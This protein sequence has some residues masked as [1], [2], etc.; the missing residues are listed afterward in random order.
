MPVFQSKL[1]TS[2]DTYKDNR[3]EMLALVTK[4]RDLEKRAASVSSKELPRFE[5]RG[6]LLPRERLKRLLDPGA[7][8]IEIGSMSGYL[9]DIDDPDKTV[10]G[11][12]L[13]AGIG[14]ISGVRCMVVVND[15]AIGAGALI[16]AGGEKFIRCQ[17]L[18][19]ANK[20]PFVQLVESAGADMA[21]Y[22]IEG[23]VR[24]GNLF[25]NLAR[26]SA[27]GCP[28]VTVLHGVSTAG[29]AY[30]SGLSDYVVAVRGRGRAFLAGPP[31]LKAATGEIASDE[32]LGGAEMHA[33]SSGLVEYLAEDDADGI[34][35][36]REVVEHL[37]WNDHVLLPPRTKSTLEPKYDP[38][39]IAGLVPLDYR[40]PYDV[41]ELIARLVDGSYMLDFKPRYGVTTV[42]VHGE[43][44]GQTCAFIGNNGPIDNAGATKAAQ[45]IQL[46][47]QSNTPI[48]YLQNTT[49]FMVGKEHESGGMIKH[50]SKMI[51][52]VTNS[53]VPQVTLMVGASFGAGNF[54][55][56]GVGFDPDL[57]FSWPNSQVGLMGAEQAAMTMRI[58]AERSA[59]R[60]G[61]AVNDGD[62]KALE[63]G[64][65][66]HFDYQSNPFYYA[67]QNLCDGMIDPRDTRKVL[68]GL[69]DMF[70]EREHRKMFSN[71]FGV[72]RL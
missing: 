21:G 4:M 27:A 32:E 63:A 66:K 29:G 2:S 46:N 16:R 13:L 54:G 42:C 24:G 67:G 11:G 61:H 49:G 33:T 6:Q 40:K 72:A 71:S 1:N 25:R 44:F 39:E 55:M 35:M 56:C 43:I 69:F 47:C 26:L 68:H 57:S 62:L 3:T 37:G 38:D 23:F 31:L 18:A 70:R 28:V 22:T 65:I 45:F 17:E 5:K 34:R 53:S 30:L 19:L 14:V 58:V 59:E 8:F 52:A 36:A 48:V 64:I 41:K 7:P 50:G 51:Q 12:S 15:S 60:R 20:L 10:V 9:R